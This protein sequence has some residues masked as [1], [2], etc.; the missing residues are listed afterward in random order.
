MAEVC[1][2]SGVGNPRNVFDDDRDKHQLVEAGLTVA[3]A[4]SARCGIATTA[5]Q[6]FTVASRGNIQM[7]SGEFSTATHW[8]ADAHRARPISTSDN[9]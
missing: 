3:G 6:H 9:N 8:P 4:E 1:D 7:P 5:P 2:V